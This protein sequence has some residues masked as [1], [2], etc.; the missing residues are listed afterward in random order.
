MTPI[1]TLVARHLQAWNAEPGPERDRLVATTYAA[2][3]SVGEPGAA[4]R[5]HE[6]MAE[7]ISR[8]QAQVPGAALTRTGPVQV[9][10][11]LVTYSWSLGAPGQPALAAGRD[12]LLLDDHV[13]SSLYV[14]IDA[15]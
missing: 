10:Q 6:G 2:D 12:V 1:E 3:V 7:A 9:A 11:D 13:V 15:T 4:Y 5:G 8:L 14:V